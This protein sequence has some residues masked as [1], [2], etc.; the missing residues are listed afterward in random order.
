M[1]NVLPYNNINKFK[2]YLIPY[3]DTNRRLNK[4]I[5]VIV[6]IVVSYITFFRYYQ[7]TVSKRSFDSISNYYSI[8]IMDFYNI[9]LYIL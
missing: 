5:L 3:Y 1:Y 8:V 7:G 2:K 9:L 4:N 6:I